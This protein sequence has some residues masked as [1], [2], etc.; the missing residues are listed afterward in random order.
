MTKVR[1]AIREWRQEEERT[2]MVGLQVESAG[3]KRGEAPNG[4]F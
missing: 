4:E 2:T 1:G 3:M